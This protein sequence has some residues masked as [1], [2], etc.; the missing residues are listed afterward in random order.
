MFPLKDTIPGLRRPYVTY[1]L[2]AAN[3]LVFIIELLFSDKTRIIGGHSVNALETIFHEYGFIAARISKPEFWSSFDFLFPNSPVLFISMFTSIFLHGGWTHLIS[4]MWALFIF[5]DNVED[6]MGHFKFL[7][8]YILC[9]LAGNIMQFASEPFSNIPLIGASGA[10]AGIMGAYLVLFPHSKVITLFLLI[11]FP[12]ILPI[13]API[14]L[15][16]WFFLQFLNGSTTILSNFNGGGVAYWA[17][18]GGFIFGM[19]TFK[20]FER[21]YR[22]KFKNQ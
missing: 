9:G 17:H 18:I 20:W 5:G 15:G 6:K 1:S 2:I 11:I 21:N 8:F 16:V 19:L 3:V 7:L 14:Y 4:N 10:I 22:I 12:L 13:P